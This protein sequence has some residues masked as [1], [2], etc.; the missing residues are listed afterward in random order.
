MRGAVV[1]PGAEI[2]EFDLGG[3]VV[4]SGSSAPIFSVENMGLEDLA[5]SD[6]SLLIAALLSAV[7]LAA[8][9]NLVGSF[10]WGKR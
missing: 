9:F 3:F 7:A 5:W 8:A 10:I 1:C 4:C 6:V 2:P